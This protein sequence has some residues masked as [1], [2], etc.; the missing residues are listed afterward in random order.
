M[1]SEP[2]YER[3]PLSHP[4]AT[5]EQIDWLPVGLAAAAILSA[6]ALSQGGP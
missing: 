1:G 3:D 6:F 4:A 2:G 5:D